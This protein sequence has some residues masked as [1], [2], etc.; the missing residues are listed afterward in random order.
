MLWLITLC[1]FIGITNAIVHN[2]V[3]IGL[4]ASWNR[5]DFLPNLIE[6]VASFN[7]SLYL[8]T[9]ETIY[10]LGDGVDEELDEES[11]DKDIYTSLI[12]TLELDEYSKNFINFN[13]V[14]KKYL[15]RVVSHYAYYESVLAKYGNRLKTECAH[16]SFGNEVDTKNG[17]LQTWLLYNDKI[18]CSANDLFALRTD[19]SVQE[20]LIV[21]GSNEDAPL[22]VLYGNPVEQSTKDFLKI[23]YPDAKAGKIRFVWRYIPS[24]TKN[25]V[26]LPGYGVEMKLNNFSYFDSVNS[27][28]SSKL[29]LTKDL[30]QIND[31]VSIIPL[32]KQDT[33]QLGVKFTSFIL[34]N[35]YKLPKYELLSTILNNFPKFVHYIAKLPKQLNHEKVKTKV[36]GNE[37][38]GF[39]AQSYGIYI[40]GSPIHP[41]EM[42][43][44]KLANK[45]KDEL[46]IIQSL[47]K[48]GFDAV[49]SKLLI[50]KFALLSAVKQ[51]QFRSGNTLMGNNENRFRVYDNAFR[52]IDPSKGGVVFLNDIEKDVTF[53]EYTTDRQEAYLGAS[54]YK[55]KPNQIPLLKENIHDLIF[56]LNFANKQQLRVF[57]TLSKAILDS[58]IPQQVGLIPVIGEDP[59]DEVIARKFYY[60]A[61]YST[62][63]EALALLYQYFE[64]ATAEEAEKLLEKVPVPEN[65]Q[66][67]FDGILN[68]FSITEASVICNGVIYESRSPNWQIAM[69][70]QISQ[71]VSL[72]KRFLRESPSDDKLK[73]SLY[74]NAKNKRDL[75]IIPLEPSEIIYKSIDRELMSNSVVFKK[76]DK[77]TGVSGTFWLVSDFSDVVMINQLIDLLTVLKKQPIQVRVLNTGN[78][79]FF[80]NLQGKFKLSALSNS[81]IEDIIELLSELEPSK[82]VN[83]SMKNL[84]ESKHLA[85]H[86]SFLL[87]NSRYFRLDTPLD[88]SDLQQIIEYEFS[89]RL[90]LFNDVISAYPDEFDSKNI[91]DFNSIIS[92]LDNMDWFDLVS[93]IVTKSFH[94]DDKMF[95]VDVNRFDFSPL[96]FSNSVD[97]NKYNNDNLVDVL[98][99][100]NPMSELSPKMINIVNSI[101]DFPFVNIRILLQP[102]V[103]SDEE[104]KISSFYRGSYPSSTLKFDS[105]GKWIQNYDIDIENLPENFK[106]STELDSPNKWI[107]TSNKATTDMAN[108]DINAAN[109]QVKA[110][111]LLK[112]ILVEGY[113]RDIHTGKAPDGLKYFLTC[114]NDNFH[115]DTNVM[116]SIDYF[117][118]KAIPGVCLL[119]SNPEYG[120]LSASENKFASN[121]QP[122]ENVT[123]PIFSID[124]TTVYPRVIPSDGVTV[125]D[126]K[127]HADINIFTIAGGQ[128]Y[129]KLASIMIASVRAHNPNAT[130]KFW[131]LENFL[132]PQFKKLLNEL[133]DKY[134]IEYELINYKW[135]N[136]L[137]KQKTKE[138]IIWGY[139]ILFLDV[140]FPQDLDRVI[141]IDADQTCRTDLTELTNLDLQGAPYGFTPMCESREEMEG[142]RF[143]KQGYWSEV[144]KD[145]LKYHISALFVVDLDKFR[146]IRAGDRLRTHYQKLSSDPNSLS[147]LDQD[148]PN[149]MQRSIKIFSLPQEWL[150]CETWCSN[151]S[152]KSAKMIDLCNNPVT[153]ENK[154]VTAK[155]LIPE[156]TDYEKEIDE[157]MNDIGKD[158]IEEED[159]N[160]EEN[161]NEVESDI[162]EDYHDEL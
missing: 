127:K 77:E 103:E 154:L 28:Q 53:S 88:V 101:R 99:I 73:H 140:L 129:E 136:F 69:S 147:N 58:G 89:Q 21:I 111:Y 83:Q 126:K 39:S 156:W 41:L 96:D 27:P 161:D 71:D 34:S 105:H 47:V 12:N 50:S 79:D 153:K 131:I 130:I 107:V 78:G 25:P 82:G 57:F 63:P 102:R 121:D 66:V 5:I 141:F 145:D 98:V 149:N 13:V 70:K 15:P 75:R 67:S 59:L 144:L 95:V 152:L 60:L 38:V 17:E 55:L 112:N 120:L 155:R 94:T 46:K 124:G 118:L 93:S 23:L 42:D 123:I 48:L 8:P 6:S 37:D 65:F 117:Q 45:L 64:S 36:T 108:I 4:E 113:A 137:R 139:K 100:M 29:D 7:E 81:Q 132:T 30:T 162:E 87:F 91:G 49:Q 32:Q 68:K 31:S 116:T 142:Y 33:F 52:K 51:T 61:A 150:W 104:V 143:W 18:Y 9:I 35:K 160:E 158:V 40:N 2:D 122:L 62:A 110:K 24:G 134:G 157:L 72:I 26:S 109:T 159:N 133:S 97:V 80:D 135:P 3:S 125:K 14:Y 43:I 85:V 56:A 119:S 114:N 74:S 128:L 92:G 19:K 138:R 84:L 90:N 22:L 54:S 146:S 106:Y 86:H 1:S 20:P 10:G 16:D 148:L 115:T 44:F 11:S 76:L 151:E